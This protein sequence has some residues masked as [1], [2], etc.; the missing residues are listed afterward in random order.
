MSTF[1][2]YTYAATVDTETNEHEYKHHH[3]QRSKNK[4]SQPGT[5]LKMK[6]AALLL[7]CPTEQLFIK[8]VVPH[9]IH[10]WRRLGINLGVPAIEVEAIHREEKDSTYA[11]IKMFTQWL[12]DGA[13][14]QG[15]GCTWKELLE[16][17][18]DSSGLGVSSEIEQM[19]T[20]HLALVQAQQQV[21]LCPACPILQLVSYTAYLTNVLQAQAS[22]HDD[23]PEAAGEKHSGLH[24]LILVHGV[25][26]YL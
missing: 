22:V 9:V 10:V 12:C 3:V 8:F 24:L 13:H 20:K 26:R 5:D 25:S 6:D 7:Q 1:Y 16:A 15:G 21:S 4:A 14:Q 17:V 23:V 11:C 19:V 18:S 2:V